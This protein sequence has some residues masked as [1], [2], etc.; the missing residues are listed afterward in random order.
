MEQLKSSK[1]LKTEK[2]KIS[3]SDLRIAKA[4]KEK[5]GTLNY[6]GVIIPRW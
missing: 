3:L 6:N 1:M 5:R 4:I 2:K